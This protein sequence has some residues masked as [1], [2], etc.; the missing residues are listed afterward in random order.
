MLYAQQNSEI[1]EATR[2]S[3]ETP[4]IEEM[5]LRRDKTRDYY[6]GAIGKGLLNHGSNRKIFIHTIAKRAGKIAH[7]NDQ[8]QKGKLTI[9]ME[10][11][12]PCRTNNNYYI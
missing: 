1:C 7:S 5:P 12:H 3:T 6:R 4:M 10:G 8:K 11:R 2:N 9:K